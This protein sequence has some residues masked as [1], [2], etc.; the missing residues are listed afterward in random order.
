MPN[1]ENSDNQSDNTKSEN[2]EKSKRQAPQGL[3]PLSSRRFLKIFLF[4]FAHI[5]IID[6][7][8]YNNINIVIKL[9]KIIVISFTLI[10]FFI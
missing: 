1:P 8:V 10:T 6:Q 3:R 4:S 5:V 7:L 2:N 9:I